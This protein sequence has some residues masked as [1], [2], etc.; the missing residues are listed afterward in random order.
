MARPSSAGWPAPP[1]RRA[2][3]PGPQRKCQAARSRALARL[4]GRRKRPGLV[5]E[6]LEALLVSFAHLPSSCASD[7]RTLPSRTVDDSATAS[8]PAGSARR[9]ELE[10]VKRERGVTVAPTRAKRP[11][12][13]GRLPD[14]RFDDDLGRLAGGDVRPERRHVTASVRPLASQLERVARIEV[15]QLVGIDPMRRGLSPSSSR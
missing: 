9:P 12:G 10:A 2:D 5:Q 1:R 7:R 6:G 3:P 15:P 14:A 11:H 13:R 8:V 4:P